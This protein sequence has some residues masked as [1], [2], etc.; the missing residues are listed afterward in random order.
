MS[1]ARYSASK[2]TVLI[3]DDI[4]ENLH[5]LAGM[6]SEQ[7]YTVRLAPD[8]QL[9]LQFVQVSPPDLILLDI[10]M[11]DMDGYEVCKELKTSTTTQDIPVIFISALDEVFDKVKAFS[12]GGVDYIT[13]PFELQEVLA[14]VENQLRLSRLSKQLL[15]QNTRLKRAEEALKK[16]RDF[17]LTLFEYFPALIWQSGLDAKCNYFNQAWLN[18][19]GRTF[20]QEIGN[21]WTQGVHPDDLEQ[22]LSTYM[23]AFEAHEPFAMEYRLRRSDGEYRW[24]LDIGRPFND[25]NNNF[26]GYVGC[27]YDISDRKQAEEASILEERNRMAR[28][29]HD[30]L[31][32]AFTGILI[33]VGAATGVIAT[34]PDAAQAHLEMVDELARTGLAEARRS[35]IALRPKLLEEGD[36]CSALSHLVTQ[37]K[38]CADTHLICE[39]VGTAYP[40]P[41]DVESNLLR[42]GQEALTN[43]I[44]YAHASVIRIE[45]VYERE[46]FVLRVKDNGQGFEV[47]SISL[48]GSFGL[49]GI[50]ER[51]ERIGGELAIQSELGRGTEIVVAIHRE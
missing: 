51:A 39:M 49:L 24:I 48:G 46:Q 41:P 1:N 35:V 27:C 38:T 9:A 44:K 50:T 15:E 20:E 43:A 23:Q 19:T 22:C 12:L 14:R 7:G 33:H 11:P 47:G 40:L 21:G 28:E 45:L 18:F 3:V 10:L 8:G 26:A 4:P 37:M 29:I 5:L 13:K 25:L 42:I 16:S 17:Y 36:L 34:D 32:Q 31:A 2:G 6:L 30:T